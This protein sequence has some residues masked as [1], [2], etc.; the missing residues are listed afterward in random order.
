MSSALRAAAPGLSCRW[1]RAIC[2]LECRRSIRCA[3]DGAPLLVRPT[4]SRS[5]GAQVAEEGIGYARTPVPR[6]RQPEARAWARVRGCTHGMRCRVL[7]VSAVLRRRLLASVVLRSRPAQR[8]V[9][10]RAR[11]PGVGAVTSSKACDGRDVAETVPRPR[12]TGGAEHVG[13]PRTC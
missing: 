7:R 12:A 6:N 11:A 3:P 2:C 1:R 5:Y 10:T 9:D 4:R 13:H 8:A